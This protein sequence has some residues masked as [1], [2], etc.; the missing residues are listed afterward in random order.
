[1]STQPL[2]QDALAASQTWQ[3]YCGDNSTPWYKGAK[4]DKFCK[5]S[6]QGYDL[7]RYEMLPS[8][9]PE[10]SS[11]DSVQGCAACSQN[12]YCS[13]N[14][15]ACASQT[16]EPSCERLLTCKWDGKAC[17]TVSDASPSPDF[18]CGGCTSISDVNCT[19][20][21]VNPCSIPAWCVDP[22]K[23]DDHIRY[24]VCN[25]LY[26]KDPQ[27]NIDAVVNYECGTVG[28]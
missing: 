2:P 24:A 7:P 14:A 26:G 11:G 27:A 13:F 23:R 10:G 20:K 1:M 6:D 25:N 28:K 18:N 16:A 4:Y 21:N 9:C 8:L 5:T 19:E 15:E 12:G 22:D 3:D 17:S